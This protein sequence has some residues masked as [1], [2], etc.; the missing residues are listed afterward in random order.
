M[1]RVANHWH[2][3]ESRERGGHIRCVADC[4]AQLSRYAAG[5]RGG[6]AGDLHRWCTARTRGS[7]G[8][9]KS[10]DRSVWARR[11][12]R[13][14]S[15]AQLS[16][17]SDERTEGRGQ[18]RLRPGSSSRHRHRAHGRGTVGEDRRSPPATH[19]PAL[20][21]CC[22]TTTLASADHHTS[23]GCRFTTTHS[24]AP[25]TVVHRTTSANAGFPARSLRPH[26]LVDPSTSTGRQPPS[27][28]VRGPFLL[29]PL[30]DIHHPLLRLPVLHLLP[31]VHVAAVEQPRVVRLIL[32][33][34][35][36][37]RLPSAVRPRCL[38]V[39]APHSAPS[40]SARGRLR[41]TAPASHRPWPCLRVIDLVLL[42]AVAVLVRVIVLRFQRQPGERRA[43]RARRRSLRR[44]RGRHG[45]RA[46][47]PSPAPASAAPA[48]LLLLP[49]PPPLRLQA[50]RPLHARSQAAA[51]GSRVLRPPTRP[52]L[53]PSITRSPSRFRCLPQPVQAD[54][55]SPSAR[56]PG[57]VSSSSSSSSRLLS[58]CRR[59]SPPSRC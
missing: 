41:R 40:S 22:R 9:R 13:M 45:R 31:S 36:S 14:R 7:N 29:C 42:A 54:G 16:R 6:E 1:R 51:P 17:R 3:E 23:S 27:V 4:A 57:A 18:G 50:L 44:S 24:T 59:C 48:L 30:N 53:L 12:A 38:A 49:L 21:C 55:R 25:S 52:F 37:S 56:L 33:T 11:R 32:A 20:C 8:Q 26:R 5:W 39:H 15:S 10:T 2:Q 35:A 58:C 28:A 34:G 47:A 46:A 43:L 19:S